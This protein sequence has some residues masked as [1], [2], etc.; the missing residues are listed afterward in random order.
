MYEKLNKDDFRYLLV[1]SREEI[2]YILDILDDKDAIDILVF[3][4]FESA[5][6]AKLKGFFDKM[7]KNTLSSYIARMLDFGILEYT[8]KQEFKLSKLGTKFLRTTVQLV[9]EAIL[10]N[11]IQDERI[12]EMI[13]QRIGVKELAQFKKDRDENRAKGHQIGMFRTK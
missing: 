4:N 13:T 1:N 11:E 7:D 6:F 9:I 5:T 8:K 2:S 12:K 10:S 3:L